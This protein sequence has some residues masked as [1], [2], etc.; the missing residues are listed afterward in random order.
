MHR[1]PG[2]GWAPLAKRSS[3][4]PGKRRHQAGSRLPRTRNGELSS[5]SVASVVIHAESPHVRALVVCAHRVSIEY[6]GHLVLHFSPLAANW[7]W[8]CSLFTRVLVVCSLADVTKLRML[9][10]FQGL[11]SAG[12][13]QAAHVFW[14][15]SRFALPVDAL[16]ALWLCVWSGHVCSSALCHHARCLCGQIICGNQIVSPSSV[17]ISLTLFAAPAA[18][19]HRFSIYCAP[20]PNDGLHYCVVWQKLKNR[21]RPF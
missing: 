2:R 11:C 8:R 18:A 5:S 1:S 9:I 10:V 17:G 12:R 13:F 4:S 19:C 6:S 16:Y 3:Q 7:E 20:V 14:L 15:D 21:R